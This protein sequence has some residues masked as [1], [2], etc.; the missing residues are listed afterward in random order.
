MSLSD[1]VY[2]RFYGISPTEHTQIRAAKIRR[3]RADGAD[4]KLNNQASYRNPYGD[5][6]SEC[7][8]AWDEGYREAG[9]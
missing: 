2:K 3:A 8:I 6:D 5:E 9:F 4:A 1:A 7:Q